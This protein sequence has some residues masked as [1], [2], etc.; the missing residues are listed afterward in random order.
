M[1]NRRRM[2]GWADRRML[3]PIHLVVGTLA[4]AGC[5][6]KVEAPVYE[7][8]P[9]TRRDIVVSVNATGSIQPVDSVEIKSKASGEIIKVYVQ[10]GD[11]VKKGQLLVQIDPRIPSATL[12]QA[13]ADLEVAQAQAT[14]AAST[15]RRADDLWKSKSIT[16][17]EYEQAR[18]T[19]AQAKAAVV[20]AQT[21]LDNAKIAYQDT[22]VRAPKDGVVLTKAID[23]GSVIQSATGTV[24]GGSVLMKMA[25][26]DSVQVRAMVDE[27]DIG[28]LAADLEVSITVDA[29]PNRPFAGRVL[30]IEPQSVV[31][32]Q[33]TMFPVL[34][35]LPNPDHLLRPGMNAEIAITVGNRRGVVALQNAALRTQRDVA[36]AAGVIGLTM[37]QVNKQLADARAKAD[38]SSAGQASLGA[39]PRKDGEAAARGGEK[40][41]LPDGREVDAPAGVDAK[42]ANELFTKMASARTSGG[43]PQLSEDERAIMQALR[44][45][46]LMGGGGRGA[47]GNAPS[48]GMT[49]GAMPGGGFMI[50]MGGPPGGG[51][52]TNE[53]R[54]QRSARRQ[55]QAGLAFGGSYIV[56]V[57]KGDVISAVPV[58]T[59]LTDLDYSEITSGLTEKDSVVVLP[60]ASLIAAQQQFQN[61]RN[62]MGALPGMRT[63]QP[64]GGQGRR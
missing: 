9:V 23:V 25:N 44:Q 50:Q 5:E 52:Q 49:G 8:I 53:A 36:S 1:T 48:G 55:Q 45:A 51:G 60:S 32:Q 29:Y 62:N 19:A 10:T 18:Y 24:S 3:W 13:K 56:F 27:T 14:N 41:K 35:R 30:K 58:Q 54:L 12:E 43:F 64:A 17:Q 6:K 26:L 59:G 37:D 38:T 15:L 20:R 61:M 57:K 11:A 2:G 7:V 22:D 42:K 63:N 4:L 34:V 16:E 46:G 33:V 31:Q 28:K 39:A 21:S 40:I 47:G